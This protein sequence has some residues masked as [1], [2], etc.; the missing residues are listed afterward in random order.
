MRC[1]DTHCHYN[2]EP[3]YSG[4]PSHFRIQSSDPILSANWQTHFTTA[5]QQGVLAGV[6][7]GADLKNSQRAIEL[8]QLE[9]RLVA[10]IGLHPDI[11]EQMV[12]TFTNASPHATLDELQTQLFTEIDRLS[13]ELDI[14]A[15]NSDIVAI[16]ET[17][18]DYYFFGDDQALNTVLRRGQERLFQNQLK[19]AHTLQLPIIVHTRDKA[20]QAY[21][22]AL[23]TI[24]DSHPTSPFVLHC[25]SGPENY[26]KTA[27][28]AHAYLGFDGNLSY[29]NADLL[30]H[31]LQLA[32]VDRILVETDAPYLPPV[33]Y[34]GQ[35]CEPW[36]VIKV[37][38]QVCELKQCSEEQ[39]LVNTASFFGSS[40]QTLI[41]DQ[42]S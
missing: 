9:P 11:I 29:K 13:A 16:G 4:K 35:V 28:D 6:V 41:T 42:T 39:L 24:L 14:L 40:V 36:M 18:L 37:A 3:L 7:V 21:L 17:G 20:E 8:H 27:I 32:P 2:L 33:P 25:V 23:Q 12:T 34:R 30:R 26:I 15:H 31:I 19:L 38:E 22:D 10:S 5:Q 1:I